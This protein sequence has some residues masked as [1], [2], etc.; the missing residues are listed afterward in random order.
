MS[1]KLFI[2]EFSPSSADW[3][4]CRSLSVSLPNVSFVVGSAAAM[5]AR[6]SEAYSLA[7]EKAVSARVRWIIS[8]LLVACAMSCERSRSCVIRR[9]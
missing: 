5:I 1:E 4:Y 7:V 6:C 3:P 8:G 2:S 9:W